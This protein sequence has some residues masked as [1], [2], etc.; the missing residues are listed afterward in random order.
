M[1]QSDA[2]IGSG[3]IVP[4]V[5][6]FTLWGDRSDRPA[7]LCPIFVLAVNTVSRNNKVKL[8]AC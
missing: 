3:R 1:K 4:G 8:T 5:V 6:C 2:L 7:A